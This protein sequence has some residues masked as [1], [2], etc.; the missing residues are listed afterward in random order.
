MSTKKEK[1]ITQKKIV[2]LYNARYLQ[3]MLEDKSFRLVKA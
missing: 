1:N 3:K 2:L